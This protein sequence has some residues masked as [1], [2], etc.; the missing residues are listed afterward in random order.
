MVYK[1]H[2]CPRALELLSCM[3]QVVDY[4]QVLFWS[5]T[6]S[7]TPEIQHLKW[8]LLYVDKFMQILKKGIT[9]WTCGEQLKLIIWPVGNSVKKTYHIYPLWKIYE[10]TKLLPMA[11]WKKGGKFVSMHHS[12][13]L[14]PPQLP[15]RVH[16]CKIM[17]KIRGV[18]YM[19]RYGLYTYV[20]PLCHYLYMY[21]IMLG[22][23]LCAMLHT[24]RHKLQHHGKTARKS[25]FCEVHLA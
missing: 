23:I 16:A 22:M 4:A 20:C 3:W 10:F 8:V 12:N 15:S 17:S 6:F 25:R 7:Q 13:V 24:V 21:G 9:W 19:F 11:V 2:P 14:T 1:N 18:N 5:H